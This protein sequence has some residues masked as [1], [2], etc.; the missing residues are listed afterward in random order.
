MGLIRSNNKHYYYRNVN[1]STIK[2][3]VFF[4][5]ENRCQNGGGEED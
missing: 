2:L 1:S 5:N 3:R 4:S